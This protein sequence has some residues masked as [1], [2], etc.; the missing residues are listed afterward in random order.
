MNN[1]VRRIGTNGVTSIIAADSIFPDA[2]PRGTDGPNPIS[3]FGSPGGVVVLQDGTIIVSSPSTRGADNIRMW[4]TNGLVATLAG[5]AWNSETN[6]VNAAKPKTANGP[7]PIAGFGRP[8]RMV[9]IPNRGVAVVDGLDHSIRMFSL[10]G[11]A[12]APVLLTTPM[13]QTNLF[14]SS[15]ILRFN[16]SAPIGSSIR[17]R[18]NGA[19]LPADYRIVGRESTS[20]SVSNLSLTD[21][22]PYSVVLSNQLGSVTGDVSTLVVRADPPSFAPT[23]AATLAERLSSITLTSPVVNGSGLIGLQW[24]YAGNPL[25]GA[26]GTT[27]RLRRIDYETAGSYVLTATNFVGTSRF[28]NHLTVVAQRIGEAVEAPELA[29][30]S[31]AGASSSNSWKLTTDQTWDG[32]DSLVTGPLGPAESST[33]SAMIEGPG[34]LRFIWRLNGSVPFSSLRFTNDFNR[35]EQVRMLY[36]W[37]EVSVSVP[38]GSQIVSWILTTPADPMLAGISGWLDNV[39]YYSTASPP[40]INPYFAGIQTNGAYGFRLTGIP[41]AVTG[42]EASTNLVDWESL[43][44]FTNVT[45]QS[46]FNDPSNTN[47]PARFYRLK[48]IP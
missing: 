3:G 7:A 8:G 22:G 32:V 35:I 19:D 39:R 4:T 17:W 14:G 29:W 34:L 13:Q 37:D 26:T 9:V 48:Q 27:L 43:G 5:R 33:V 44:L 25:V 41:G 47:R 16:A 2:Q 45:G 31:T 36:G 11:T 18:F 20:L 24:S 12:T 6:Y 46:F 30:F 28:T 40:K 38:A 42:V 10:P 23:V 1:L 21:A 15:A